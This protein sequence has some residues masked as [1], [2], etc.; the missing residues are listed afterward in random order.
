MRAEINGFGRW[1]D[2]SFDFSNGLLT[3]LYG[4]NEAGKSTLQHF[5]LFM[6]FGLPP[7]KR[8]FYKPKN[9]NRIGGTLTIMDDQIGVYTIER[10]EGQ[11]NCL[12]PNGVRQDEHWLH[13]QLKGITNEIYTSI[14]AFSAA[15]LTE[16]RQ[17][18]GEQLSDVLFSV[19]LTGASTIYQV[20]KKLDDKLG[21]LF[22]KT[23]RK[24]MINKQLKKVDEMYSEFLHS[25]EIEATYRDKKALKEKLEAEI[26]KKQFNINDLQKELYMNEKIQHVIPLL[27]EYHECKEKLT[28]FP[29]EIRFPENGVD[30]FQ[31]LKNNIIPL[32]S[33]WTVLKKN[34]QQYNDKLNALSNEIYPDRIYQAAQSILSEKRMDENHQ[35]QIKEKEREYDQL[36]SLLKEQ[37]HEIELV[38]ADL[39]ETILPFHLEATWKEIR[40]TNIQLQQEGE[41]LSEDYHLIIKE[42]NELNEEETEIKNKLISEEKLADLQVKMNEYDL[43]QTANKNEARQRKQWKQWEQKQKK[44][45]TWTLIGTCLFAMTSILMAIISNNYMLLSVTAIIILAGLIQTNLVKKSV[46]ELKETKKSNT[47]NTSIRKTERDEYSEIVKENQQLQASLQTV[48]NEKKRVGFQKL[49]WEERKRL[50]DQKESQWIDRL[51]TEQYQYPF[52]EQVEPAHWIELLHKIQQIRRHLVDKKELEE[53]LNLLYETRQLF[54]KKIETFAKDVKWEPDSTTVEQ[55]E[56]MVDDFESKK[57]LMEQYR[58]LRKENEEKE[59]ELTVKIDSYQNEM[60]ALM[61]IANVDQEEAYFKVARELEEKAYLLD[62]K[63]KIEQQMKPMFSSEIMKRLLTEQ[64]NQHEIELRITHVKKQIK[65]DQSVIAKKN[66]QLATVEMTIEQMEKSDSLSKTTFR[67]QL[68]QNKLNELAQEWALFQVAKSALAHAKNAYQKKYLTEVIQLTSDYFSKLTNGK[69]KRVYAPTT[70]KLFQ[71]EANNYLRYTVDELSQG[72]I[73]QLYV[74]LRLA[75]SKVMSNKYVIPLI[76]DDAFVHFDEER[77]EQIIKILKQFAKEQQI[78]LFTCKTDIANQLQAEHIIENMKV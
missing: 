74:S 19:S 65:A 47:F 54:I 26:R 78:L 70:S 64:V 59:S 21:A 46:N 38:E 9:S 66:K 32:Q 60:H 67:Y 41:R 62:R 27:N 57:Q 18:S 48:Q 75:I 73:D 1:V 50:F 33:E 35:Q 58:Q 7:R 69:Y 10:M 68:E 8:N 17:M 5:I 63:I 77:T 49:K 43:V 51:K 2:K 14:Y 72:T 4:E 15:D 3:C 25:K 31:L 55:I 71:V 45:S 44:L 76:I 20:E 42:Q 56:Q 37:L 30:R 39:E 11:V 23:G 52:L 61:E 40:D 24:P 16:I 53:E 22:K 6:L 34:E 28:I 12:L 29:K 13:D 36:N